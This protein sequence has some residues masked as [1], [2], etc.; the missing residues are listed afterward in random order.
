MSAHDMRIKSENFLDIF[1]GKYSGD[2]CLVLWTKQD[3]KS[4][5][6]SMDNF[7]EAAIKANSLSQHMDVYFGI[8]IQHEEPDNGGR[9]RTDTVIA[10]PGLWLDLDI[11]GPNHSAENLP[12]DKESALELLETFKLKP[13]LIACAPSSFLCIPDKDR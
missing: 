13:T 4:Y 10:I 12:P 5:F 9:G 1:Y 7:N 11:H 3:K 6:F 2:G 8:G